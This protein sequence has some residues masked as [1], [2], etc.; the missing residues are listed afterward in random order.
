MT[1]KQL[2][3]SRRGFLSGLGALAITGGTLGSLSLLPNFREKILTASS[4]WNDITQG[5]I[6]SADRMAPTFTESEI[7]QNFPYNGFYP[8]AYAPALNSDTWRLELGG[9]IKNKTPLSL[10]DLRSMQQEAQITRMICIEGWSAVGQWS[11]V[12]LHLLLHRIEADF[13]NTVVRIDCAD[14]YHTSIDMASAMHP[15]T[16]LA[17][18]FLGQPLSQSFGAPVRLRIPVKLGFKNAK[19]ITR[20]SVHKTHQGGYWEDQ[21]YN[22][23][24]GL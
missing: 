23:F 1:Y 6:L 2:T 13:H 11:G 12:P 19:F 21:G 18:N 22:W 15:Q 20:I 3:L 10:F 5:I 4:T 9:L 17:L 8:E 16:I 7:S 14:G 24:S